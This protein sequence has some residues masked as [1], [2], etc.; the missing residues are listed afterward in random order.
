MLMR[1]LTH[2][3]LIVLFTLVV[4]AACQPEPAGI[5]ELP[6]ATLM[7]ILSETP[8]VTATQVPSRTP[9][10]TYTFTPTETSIPPTPTIEPSPTMTPTIMGI[11]QSMQNVNVRE[12]P[13]ENYK[14]FTALVPGTG[15]QIIG[16]NTEQT[17]LNIRMED[18]TEGWIALR[19]VFIPP[20]PTA[21]PTLTP[22]P[23][24]TALFLGTPLP[25]AF[26]GGGTITPTPPGSI[27]T[28]TPIGTESTE[29]APVASA[30]ETSGSSVAFLNVIPEV[31]LDALNLTATVLA[32][33]AATETPTITP[34]LLP[35]AE[36]E[37]TLPPPIAPGT[38]GDATPPEVTSEASDSENQG[39]TQEQVAE[40]EGIDVFAFCD[41]SVYGLPAPVNLT[42]GTTIDIYW[43]WFAREEK[44]V[45]DH[46][47]AAS[48]DLKVNGQSVAN[49]NQFRTRIRKQGADYVTYWYVPFGPLTAGDYE[50]SYT[51][52]WSRQIGDG[53]T[54]FG[55]GT[56]KPFE[57]ESC[58]FR[59]R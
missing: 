17:W 30:S 45:L 38:L 15:V 35:T 11:V 4:L 12:G 58:K 39:L 37:I 51:V 28:A 5:V 43:A 27:S 31:N 25:T 10:P 36:R 8:R 26:I 53:Y 32:R 44:Q 49:V 46:V 29:E 57:Q 19:L 6:T 7:P 18:G 56:D 1:K 20:T 42:A 23:D 54:T 24:L 13:G 40:L 2:L 34:T 14:R 48:H 50:I 55:P 59:V 21:F 33:G 3:P 52:T 16:R 22:S 9:L 47:N 41:R